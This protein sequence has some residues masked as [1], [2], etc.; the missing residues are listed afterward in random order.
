MQA[1][2]LR[3]LYLEYFEARGHKR[4]PS[5]SLVPDDPTLLLTSAGMVQF[6]DIFWGRVEPPFPTAVTCQKCFRATDIEEVGR[7]AYHHT[8]FEMLGNFS[9]GDYF[10]RGAIELAWAF[11]TEELSIPKER[12]W[13]SVYEEDAAA[14]EIWKDVIG[15]PPERIVRLG[16]EHN[17]WG[18]VGATGP[19]GP[20]SELFYDAGEDRAC[21]PNCLGVACDCD[22]FSEI[23]NLVFME[24]EARES[25]GFSPLK[26]KN[27]DTG[28]GF[29]RTAAVLQGVVSDYEIDLFRPIVEAIEAQMP[30]EPTSELVSRRN[31]IADHIRGAVFLIGDGVLPSN[32]KQGYVLR[33]ILRRSIDAG[34]KLGLPTGSHVKLIEPVLDSLGGTY[35]EIVQ[36]RSLAEKVIAKEEKDYRRVLRDG[37]AREDACFDRLLEEG[38]KVLPGEVAFEWQDT[39]GIPRE[40]TGAWAA[41]RGIAVDEAGFERAMKEQRER[42]RA[43]MTADASVEAEA[44]RIPAGRKPTVFLGYDTTETESVIENALPPGE[45]PSRLI[46]PESPFYAEGGGQIAD[47]GVIE[48]LGRSGRAEVADVKKGPG[49]VYLHHVKVTEGSFAI[50]DRCRLVVDAER[51]KRIARNHT[52]THLLHRALRDVLGEHV[53]QS[54]S[55]VSDEE[56]RFDFSHFEKL[57]VA[58]I[59]R[60]EGAVNAIVLED[61]PVET[62]EMTLDA[63]KAS[64]AAAHFEKEYRGKERVRVVSVGDFSRELCGGTHVAR[65]GEIGLIKIVSEESIASGTRRI[66]AVTGD[67]TLVRLR[68]QETLLAQL[69]DELGGDPLEGVARLRDQIKDLQD[70]V[71]EMTQGVLEKQA[72]ALLA[73]KEEIA[74]ISLISGR[75]DRTA[76]EVKTLADLLEGG[77]RPAAV[78]LVGDADGQAVVVCKVSKGI[79]AVDAGA[80]VRELSALV[81]G[82]GG[83]NRSFAQGGGPDLTRLDQALERGLERLRTALA[84]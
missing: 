45:I 52:A 39:Y 4:L 14:Y 47:T 3:D 55:Y 21:G 8:F 29:E 22:R 74:G 83:G 18:P 16:K 73:S 75:V 44:D 24:T 76:D 11:A 19:C 70:Q 37:K 58:E 20:D 77:A 23:W 34:E 43:A 79:E 17:W 49:G 28:M 26:R 67:N 5:S 35:P 6:K 62:D 46:F 32:E 33:R 63:A 41:E 53:I 56:L 13:V 69:H 15:L 51:R 71:G 12:I 50:G 1:D 40:T 36:A 9:F 30:D 64:G 60:V 81:G 57:T 7:T 82:G 80:L 42:S 25:G 65:S 66:R 38:K 72:D 54:G 31:L 48:N 27:I 61:L 2:Q 68:G 59:A 78:L 10:K 84:A